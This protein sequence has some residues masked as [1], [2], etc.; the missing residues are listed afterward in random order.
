MFQNGYNIF[1]FCVCKERKWVRKEERGKG[2][3]GKEIYVCKAR[4]AGEE[5]K[6]R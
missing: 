5:E 2:R 6:M 4:T 1:G 3:E